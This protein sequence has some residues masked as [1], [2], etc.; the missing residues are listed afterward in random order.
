MKRGRKRELNTGILEGVM[1]E[2]EE[3]TVEM[4]SPAARL[5][6]RIGDALEEVKTMTPS[7][8]RSADSLE[9]QSLADSTPCRSEDAWTPG[10]A[11]RTDEEP[12]SEEKKPQPRQVQYGLEKFFF[13][14]KVKPAIEEHKVEILKDGGLLKRGRGRPTRE[15]AALM[16]ARKKGEVLVVAAVKD[17]N[18]AVK[19]EAAM[20]LKQK[21]KKGELGEGSPGD[22]AAVEARLVQAN[23]DGPGSMLLVK[24]S[25]RAL[26]G[27]CKKR[28]EEGAAIKLEMAEKMLEA[29][30]AFASEGEWSHAM[31][32]LY[33]KPWKSL[34]PIVEG[35]K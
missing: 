21:K 28:Q 9:D 30:S 12:V 22:A 23:V 5:S 31:S 10:V 7:S 19:E 8:L 1:S 34:K 32:K 3:E 13:G 29:R 4:D 2:D 14:K 16:E 11:S 18:R 35:R 24:N 27:A 33:M 25:N 26:K 6:W 17:F 20:M 15:A